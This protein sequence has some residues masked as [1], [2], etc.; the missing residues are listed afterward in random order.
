MKKMLIG[1]TITCFATMMSAT[2]FAGTNNNNMYA[3]KQIVSNYTNKI[4]LSRGSSNKIVKPAV[5]TN[6]PYEA[7]T[8]KIDMNRGSSN[9]KIVPVPATNLK[10]DEPTRRI[11]MNGGSSNRKVIPVP[12]TNIKD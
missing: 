11:N 6:I 1:L 4:N 9:R 12:A 2:C 10:A 3:Q 5:A 7:P 8:R